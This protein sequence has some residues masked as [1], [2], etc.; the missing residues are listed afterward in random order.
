MI[1]S[2]FIFTELATAVVDSVP[3]FPF[4]GTQN[5]IGEGKE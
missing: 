3:T 2:Y 4:L 1:C 5:A